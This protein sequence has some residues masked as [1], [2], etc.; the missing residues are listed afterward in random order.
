MTMLPKF[1]GDGDAYLFLSKFEEVCS[2]MQFPK[3]ATRYCPVGLHSV[4]LKR[5][6]KEI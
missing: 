6:S 3:W 5:F 1:S 2:M 4:G